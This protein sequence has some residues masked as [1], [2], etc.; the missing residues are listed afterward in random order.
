MQPLAPWS[1]AKV[2]ECGLIGRSDTKQ[3]YGLAFYRYPSAELEPPFFR[4]A[5]VRQDVAADVG[6]NSGRL[7]YVHGVL[8]GGAPFGLWLRPPG[9]TLFGRQRRCVCTSPRPGHGFL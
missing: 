7:E 8:P 3:S 1:I 5:H 6:R 4:T 2:Q 9:P